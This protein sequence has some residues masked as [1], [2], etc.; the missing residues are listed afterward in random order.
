MGMKENWQRYIEISGLKSKSHMRAA[1]YW[2]RWHIGTNITVICLGAV[3]TGLALIPIVPQ[4]VVALIA[5]AS[6]L[7][8]TIMSFMKPADQRQVQMEASK[9]FGGLMLKMVSCETERDYEEL[10]KELNK[11]VITAPFLM[12]K[13][14]PY[15][16]SDIQFTMSPELLLVIEEKEKDTS[17]LPTILAP[18]LDAMGVKKS[19]SLDNF[20]VEKSRS[21]E[22]LGKSLDEPDV[23]NE[24]S[25]LL[26]R[27]NEIKEKY[28]KKRRK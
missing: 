12:K 7:M 15:M 19:R 8:S 16:Y 3:T 6:T 5:A 10:W 14:D 17:H 13:Y 25:F 18:S 1:R 27:T 28:E 9:E 23:C 21:F 11:A 4:Y 22:I 26:D 24:A 2:N 20:M